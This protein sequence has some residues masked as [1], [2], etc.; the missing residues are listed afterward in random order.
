MGH[1]WIITGVYW[2]KCTK[3]QM[4]DDQIVYNHIIE[5]IH[6]KRVIF[7]HDDIQ[8]QQLVRRYRRSM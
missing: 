5:I 1:I 2:L 4:E 8:I 3:I 6:L 7:S